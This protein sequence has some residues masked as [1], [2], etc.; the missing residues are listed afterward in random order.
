VRE[1]LRTVYGLCAGRF[2]SNFSPY[3]RGSENSK[4]DNTLSKD[5]RMGTPFALWKYQAV[6][7]RADHIQR[8]GGNVMKQLC[9]LFWLAGMATL[10]AY[11]WSDTLLN[12]VSDVVH[13]M[14]QLVAF[15]IA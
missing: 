6:E 10:V 8:I 14:G 5:N 7:N 9:Y 13:F 11:G 3:G 1:V 2:G 12:Q 4:H 15:V